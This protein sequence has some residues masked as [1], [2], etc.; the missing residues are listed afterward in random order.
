MG[1]TYGIYSLMDSQL[2]DAC[3]MI[4]TEVTNENVSLCL[5]EI[6]TD[7]ERLKSVLVSEEELALVKNYLMGNYL[8]L[9]DGP[10]NSIKAIKS[11]VLSDIPL[12]NL[13]S[14]IKA[15]VSVDS[16]GVMHMAQKYFNSED[17][18]EVIVG[19]PSV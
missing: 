10:F 8:N 19:S 14:I 2:F 6:Y 15:S 1:L 9:F 13:S 11:L 12:N 3:L 17:Y 7:M 18:W 5:K 16:E 4:S